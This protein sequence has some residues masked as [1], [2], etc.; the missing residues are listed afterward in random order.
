MYAAWHRLCTLA[1]LSCNSS[2][3]G[4]DRPL[5][6]SGERFPKP[7]D[8]A[9]RRDRRPRLTASSACRG[10]AAGPNLRRPRQLFARAQRALVRALDGPD[11]VA[12]NLLR[13]MTGGQV[14]VGVSRQR[15]LNLAAYVSGV[16]AA[17]VE[18]A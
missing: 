4:G 8:F 2:C 16:R 5:G 11:L 7:S 12:G 17:G 3:T 9:A 1:T 13:V 15:R 14:P 10:R 6:R 18:Y